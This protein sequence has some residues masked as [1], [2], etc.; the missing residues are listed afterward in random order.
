MTFLAGFFALASTTSWVTDFVAE[1]RVEVTSA[2]MV[3]EPA[4]P[5]ARP[6]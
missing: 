6:W 4:S 3:N 2:E 1:P 5:Y